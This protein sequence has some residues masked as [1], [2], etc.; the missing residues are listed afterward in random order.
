MGGNT[1]RIGFGIADDHRSD[2]RHAFDLGFVPADALANLA[3]LVGGAAL[4]GEVRA[5][6]VQCPLPLA[7]DGLAG[8]P[9]LRDA[10]AAQEGAVV[11]IAAR[12][13]EA[14]GA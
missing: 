4:G 1:F 9:A 13:D 14:P 3:E 10:Y 2:A 6:L 11:A 5:L 7:G 8:V 12:L